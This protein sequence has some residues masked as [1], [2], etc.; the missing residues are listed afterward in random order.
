MDRMLRSTTP[1]LVLAAAFFLIS[2]GFTSGDAAARGFDGKVMMSKKRLPT[3]AKSKK[4]Y[5][6]K[7]RKQSTTRFKEDKKKKQWKVY[8]GAFFKRP[9]NDMEVSIKLYDITERRPTLKK[10]YEQ[11]LDQRGQKEIISYIKLSREDFGVNRRLRMT[12]EN[13]GKIL[14]SGV[15]EILGEAEKYTGE[16]NFTEAETKGR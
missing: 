13:R 7:I 15:F 9:L 4:A 12:V 14:A 6:A 16:V 3:A 1:L 5:F 11:F 8:Y 2:S 10:V